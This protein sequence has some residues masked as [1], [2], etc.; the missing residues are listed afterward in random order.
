VTAARTLGRILYR[1]IKRRCRYDASV[2]AEEGSLHL[3]RRR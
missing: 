1:I 3:E 2:F